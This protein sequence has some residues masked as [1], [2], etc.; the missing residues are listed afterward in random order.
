MH[1]HVVQTVLSECGRR[2]S[3][4]QLEGRFRRGFSRFIF[5]TSNTAQVALHP[6]S[7][8]RDPFV[9]AR[10]IQVGKIDGLLIRACYPVN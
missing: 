4:H 1:R 8:L 10:G 9:E 7:L 5:K 3:H 2:N 6:G